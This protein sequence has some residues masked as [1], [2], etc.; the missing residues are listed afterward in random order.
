MVE[1]DLLYLILHDKTSNDHLILKYAKGR[2]DPPKQN[3]PRWQFDN[4]NKTM[5]LS[6]VERSDSGTY[7]LAIGD[8]NEK[9]K[10]SY[11]LQLKV[12]GR[13]TSVL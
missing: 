10:K 5:I 13:T 12:E 8:A 4:D 7:I 6:S 9:I 11:S 3:A 2:L 1:E